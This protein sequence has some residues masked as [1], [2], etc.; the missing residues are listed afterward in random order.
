MKNS[1]L[2]II[3]ISM[4][5]IAMFLTNSSCYFFGIGDRQCG[6]LAIGD[7][8]NLVNYNDFEIVTSNLVEYDNSVFIDVTVDFKN[9]NHEKMLL[10]CDLYVIYNGRAVAQAFVRNEEFYKDSFR[11]VTIEGVKLTDN[12]I[13]TNNY[14]IVVDYVK[15][16]VP[17]YNQKDLNCK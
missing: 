12:S 9:N 14:K 6:G 5:I 2:S 17:Q 4:L 13:K 10:N 7:Y 15:I 3:M 11:N 1:K 16:K 8:G